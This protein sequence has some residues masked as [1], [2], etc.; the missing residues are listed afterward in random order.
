MEQLN[1][2]FT[3]LAE[4]LGISQ[5]TGSFVAVQ[6]ALLFV[7]T[8]CLTAFKRRY[9]SPISHIPGPA[10]ASVSRFW[11]IR[12]IW[13][14]K[15]NLSVIS[16]HDKHGHFVR[17]AP[18]E[19]SV[20]HPS[21]VKTLLIATLPK[22]NWYR[23]ARFPDYRFNT[24][25]SMLDPKDK[26]ECAKYIT[27]GY[28]LHNILKCEPAMDKNI[29]QLW[30]W[31]DKFAIEKRP[32]DLDK[33][34]TYV[35]FDITGEVLFSKPFGFIERGQDVRGSIFMN[36]AMEMY[37][38]YVGYFQI[39]HYI[40][41]NPLI[42]WLGVLPLGHLFDTTMRAL[43]E[44]QKDPDARQDISSHWFRGLEKAKQ[45]RSRLFD[46]RCL[47]AFATANVGAGS[48]TVSTGLQSFIYHLLRHP[49]GWQKI[50]H[51]IETA[52]KEGRCEGDVISYEDALQ[53]PYL[54]ACIKEGLRKF[55][56]VSMGL[57]RVAPK[58]GV[59]I[60]DQFFPEGIT[61]TVSP[62]VVHSSLELWGPDAREFNPD[63]WFRADA[64]AKEK[65]FIPWGVGYASCPGQHISRIQLSKILA[66]IVRDYTIKQVNPAKEWEWTAYF[67]A[68]PHNWP[69][70]VTKRPSV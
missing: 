31:M 66:T 29:K 21:G 8:I 11:H 39:L 28:L 36:L 14:G 30:A 45:D 22:G 54:Q 17:V 50:V 35:A 61:L 67:T 63:R 69:V 56:P 4:R 23:I 2:Q 43:E 9:L 25:F 64:A 46:E 20:S 52:R 12:Q 13:K 1:L 34:F 65:Y 19:V 62:S 51:E 5:W 58:G 7:T 10:F 55:S 44:R 40:F 24:P 3:F 48:D 42:T 57:P 70:Y 47:R 18:E 41:A 59:S 33:F 60:G 68:V 27:T 38:S 49:S 53:L 16:E 32:M 26:N 37:I 6:V 15:Q